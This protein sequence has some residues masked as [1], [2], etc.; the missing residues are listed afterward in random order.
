[1]YIGGGFVSC[2]LVRLRKRDVSEMTRQG[3]N[4]RG[5]K[6]KKKENKER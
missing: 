2:D 6:R 3:S 5:S 1:M 4:S